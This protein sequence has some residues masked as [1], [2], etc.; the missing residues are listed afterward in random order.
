MS[1]TELVI[2]EALNKAAETFYGCLSGYDVQVD[3]HFI[4]YLRDV[5]GTTR[6]ARIEIERELK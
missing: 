4:A 1:D 3:Y 6:L 5:S 2:M